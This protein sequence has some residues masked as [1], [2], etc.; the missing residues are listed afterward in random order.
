MN[1]INLAITNL[2]FEAYG[3]DLSKYDASFLNK[4]IQKRITDTF[5]DSLES[6]FIYLENS[7]LERELLVLSMQV[8]YSIFFRNTFTFAILEHIIL[9]SIISQK[10]ASKQKEIRIWSSACASGQETYSLAI[11]LNELSTVNNEEINYRIFATDYSE[12]RIN[13]ALLG[14]YS[15]TNLQHAS[16]NRVNQWFVHHGN[17]YTVKEDLKKHIDF[18]VFDLLNEEL[19]CPAASIFGDFDIVMCANLLFY[20]QPVYQKKIIEKALHSLNSNGYLI[21]SETERE[22]LLAQNL[23]EIFPQSGIF[24]R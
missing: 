16:M 9:P 19:S 13:E 3:T 5:C 11:L 8:N 4:S 24:R 6:Y 12:Q 20:Y 18:S 15:D 17:K 23:V 10:K 7:Y 14:Q 22:I 2:V 21:T 1:E